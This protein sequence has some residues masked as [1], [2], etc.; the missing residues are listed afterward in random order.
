MSVPAVPSNSD[1]AVEPHEPIA[2]PRGR[3]SCCQPFK[4]A[5]HMDCYLLLRSCR[6]RALAFDDTCCL[7]YLRNTDRPYFYK[8]IVFFLKKNFD[9]AT[10]S[11]HKK[12]T[13]SSFGQIGGG[14]KKYLIPLFIKKIAISFGMQFKYRIAFFYKTEGVTT[15]V[16]DRVVTGTNTQIKVIFF[17]TNNNV[18]VMTRR[19]YTAPF[20][21]VYMLY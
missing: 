7:A 4:H 15:D 3:G 17:K 9:R 13:S 18:A 8:A 6:H 16:R 11:V 12:C 1:V 14:V 10:P 5:L 20:I 21:F 2:T 19:I